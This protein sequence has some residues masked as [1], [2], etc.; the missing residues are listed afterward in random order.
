MQN[1][2]TLNTNRKPSSHD[3]FLTK[4]TRR[5]ALTGMALLL[6]AACSNSSNDYVPQPPPDRGE[7]LVQCIPYTGLQTIITIALD[8]K[9]FQTAADR[10]K[11]SV[12]QLKSSRGGPSVCSRPT[13]WDSIKTGT[14][15]A[16]VDLNF[17]HQKS[18]CVVA[19]A[20]VNAQSP[21]QSTN[22]PGAEKFDN[23]LV[24]CPI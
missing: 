1:S 7:A 20:V 6:T 19:G 12:G 3:V 10:L 24:I 18:I 14:V 13:T 2:L 4:R 16:E 9:G 11:I 17:G 23:N 22:P 8:D 21:Q 5:T 15:L